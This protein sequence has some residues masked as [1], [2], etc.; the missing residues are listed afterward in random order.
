[1]QVAPNGS[2]LLLKRAVDLC[3]ATF[4]LLCAAPL[5]VLIAVAIKMTS[6]GPILFGQERYGRNKRIFRMLKFRTMVADAD[7]LQQSLE[8]RNEMDG[9]VFKIRDDPR[10][11]R[12]GRLLRKTS[13]DELPQLLHVLTGDMSLVGPRPLP[14]RDV[15]RFTRPSDMRRFSVRPGLTCL[16][17]ISGRNGIGFEEWMRLDLTY[18]DRWSLTLD[19]Y[20]LARTIPAVLRGAGAH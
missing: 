7:R 14:L 16:W 4:A 17:Q 1:M 3:G 11:T 15:A 18:I 20:I 19:F 9:P 6:R 8:A 12:I 13:L 5:L 2:R 10:I